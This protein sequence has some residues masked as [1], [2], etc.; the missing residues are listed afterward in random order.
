MKL[1]ISNLFDG[2]S[3]SVDFICL[4][5]LIDTF[6]IE[7]FFIKYIFYFITIKNRYFI[8]RS[9]YMFYFK[10]FQKNIK[11]YDKLDYFLNF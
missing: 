2:R 3:R 7:V 10:S 6:Y 1:F 4:T 11:F 5:I 8:F 9:F